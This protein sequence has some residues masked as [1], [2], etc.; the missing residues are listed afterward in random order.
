MYSKT[1][2]LKKSSFNFIMHMLNTVLWGRQRQTL[3][4]FF[5]VNNGNTFLLSTATEK[6]TPENV[7]L[8]NDEKLLSIDGENRFFHIK[9]TFS[10]LRHPQFSNEDK[11]L[12]L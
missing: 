9:F 7:H 2:V 12:K 8:R 3:N 6:M 11:F 1:N 5:S 10:N 4:G